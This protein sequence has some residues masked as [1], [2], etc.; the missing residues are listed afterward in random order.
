VLTWLDGDT[1][2]P[3][4]QRALKR[5]NGLLAAGGDLSTRRLIAAYRRGIFPWYAEGEP[6]MWWSPDPRMVLFTR[7]VHVGHRLARTLRSGRFELR[8]NTAF[9]DVMLACAEPRPG[10]DG[11]WITPEMI[12]AYCA[13]H[14][15]GFAHSIECWHNGAL[16]GG[17]YGVMLGRMFF[18]E[19]MFTRVRDASKIALVSL[20]HSLAQL[21]VPMIDCQ[22]ETEH[23]ASM[24]GRP[25]PRSQF[26]VHL[27][28]TVD[29][30]MPK[31][32]L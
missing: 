17:L 2:F 25:I 6:I 21:D 1:P 13:L 24:G 7:E 10:Q 29:A 12:D 26:L 14:A 30:P 32:V 31:L 5:P 20:C 4:A 16:A 8:I 28:N 22:Q 3:P 15:D 11:T 19:S 9:R 27:A 18:G 23:T